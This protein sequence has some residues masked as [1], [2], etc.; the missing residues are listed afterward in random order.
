MEGLRPYYQ[1]VPVRA[2]LIWQKNAHLGRDAL[3]ALTLHRNGA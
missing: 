3:R 2:M 1:S